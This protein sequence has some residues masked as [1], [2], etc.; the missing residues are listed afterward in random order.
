MFRRAHV[1]Y[2]GPE[3]YNITTGNEHEDLYGTFEKLVR[4]SDFT[5]SDKHSVL[6]QILNLL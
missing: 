1:W 2:P 3:D 6:A 4:I 5:K